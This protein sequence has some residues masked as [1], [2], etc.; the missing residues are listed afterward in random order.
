ME[1]LNPLHGTAH[2]L[3]EVDSEYNSFFTC[4]NTKS[5]LQKN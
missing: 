3:E 1:D 2:L 5:V 4:E